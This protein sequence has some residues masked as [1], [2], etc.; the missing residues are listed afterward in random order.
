LQT[1]ELQYPCIDVRSRETERAILE[2]EYPEYLI[3]YDQVYAFIQGFAAKRRGQT[4]VKLKIGVHSDEYKNSEKTR[5]ANVRNGEIK[6]KNGV[7][8]HKEGF[9]NSPEE[10]QRKREFGREL[11]RQKKGI[12]DP[13]FINSAE[14]KERLRQIGLKHK[15]NGTGVFS[16]TYEQMVETGRNVGLSNGRPVR[17]VSPDQE[18]FFFNSL[19]EAERELGIAHSSLGGIIK[20]G[21]PFKT[22][23]WK[24]WGAFYLEEP[25]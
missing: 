13:E 3:L 8:F 18:E 9:R 15:E 10:I 23:K 24:G 22:G 7:G 5:E 20:K 2:K 25:S 12:H 16:R 14:N 6:A 17:L 1:I 21:T 11:V 19:R 4:A